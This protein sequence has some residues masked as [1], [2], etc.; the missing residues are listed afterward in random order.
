[1]K[2]KKKKKET[3]ELVIERERRIVDQHGN[4]L[5]DVTVIERRKPPLVFK[6]TDFDPPKKK[7]PK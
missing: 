6:A 3:S 7:K 4:Y 5:G 1:M 2:P